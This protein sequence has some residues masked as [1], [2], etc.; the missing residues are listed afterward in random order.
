MNQ[1]EL[2]A[3][4]D[5]IEWIDPTPENE[6]WLNNLQFDYGEGPFLVLNAVTPTVNTCSAHPQKLYL[7]K[8]EDETHPIETIFCGYWFRHV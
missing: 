4:G 7:T 1:P 8:I 3:T 2:F 5:V 6:E